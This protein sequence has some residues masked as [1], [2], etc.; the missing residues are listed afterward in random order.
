MVWYKLQGYVFSELHVS[1][2]GDNAGQKIHMVAKSCQRIRRVGSELS[3]KADK[4]QQ[5]SLYIIG[6]GLREHGSKF[7][8]ILLDPPWG[9]CFPCN[10]CLL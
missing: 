2:P 9:T 4:N 8:L 6:V 7:I 3:C 5:V 1:H 10:R